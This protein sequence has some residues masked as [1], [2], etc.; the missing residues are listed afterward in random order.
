M[1]KYRL[2]PSQTQ[3]KILEEQLELCRQT[4]NQL[5]QRCRDAYRETGRLPTQF[6]LNKA[7]TTHKRQRPEL[8]RVH[9]QVLQNVSKRIKDS[10]TNYYARRKAGLKA[11]LPRYKKPGRY[12]S[13]TYPQS[14]FKV[15]NCRLIL[16]KIGS[17]KIRMHKPIKSRVK[18]LTVK[19]YPSGKWYA[20]FSCIVDAQP[21]EKPSEDVGIDVGLDCFATLSDGTRI[22]NPR[23]YRGEERRLKR[24]HRGLSRKDRGSNN[25]VKAKRKLARLYERVESRRTDFIHKTSRMIADQYET[26]YVEDLNISNMVKNHCLAKSISDASWGRFVGMLCYKEEESGGRV[27]HVNPKGTSQRCSMCG[28]VV[29]KSLSDRVH[30]CPWCGLVLDRD[31]NASRNVLRI[32]RGSPE[33]RPVEGTASTPL[34]EVVQV[35]PMNQE[36]PCESFG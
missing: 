32:G 6:D 11:G 31:L 20:C 23:F 25:W 33:Y 8:R 12:R 29:E 27:V 16:S 5:L 7:L 34:Q 18:T 13:I 14:G 2:Y 21:R 35:D 28:E 30:E 36:A 1:Y 9:S 10:Y 4:H 17:L 22:G 26:V 15:D 3:T 19:R 24:L